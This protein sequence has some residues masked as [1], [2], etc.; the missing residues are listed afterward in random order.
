MSDQ[1]D[2]APLRW[3]QGPCLTKTDEEPQSPYARTGG[4]THVS[5][6]AINE[7][8]SVFLDHL[9]H[10]QQRDRIAQAAKHLFHPLK[11]SSLFHIFFRVT[12]QHFAPG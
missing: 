1:Q 4:T 8:C 12:Q 5:K 9:F 10:R 2:Q 3:P 7:R 6:Y 11:D